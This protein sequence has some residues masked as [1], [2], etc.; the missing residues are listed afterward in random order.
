[1][2]IKIFSVQLNGDWQPFIVDELY[3]KLEEEKGYIAPL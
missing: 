1:M 3:K 2:K